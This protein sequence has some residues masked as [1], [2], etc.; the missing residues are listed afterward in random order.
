M[1]IRY[2]GYVIEQTENGL[3]DIID[4]NSGTVE[5]IEMNIVT[6]NYCYEYINDFLI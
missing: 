3:F 1:V 5:C 4:D 6:L 2:K